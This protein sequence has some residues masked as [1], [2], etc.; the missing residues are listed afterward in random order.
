VLYN[1][2]EKVG[3]GVYLLLNLASG[4]KEKSPPLEEKADWKLKHVSEFEQGMLERVNI[5]NVRI[6]SFLTS[7]FLR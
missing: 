2:G 1:V 7:N 5:F 3:D 6:R 4:N